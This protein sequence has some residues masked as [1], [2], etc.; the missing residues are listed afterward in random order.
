MDTPFGME[1]MSAFS[2]PGPKRPAASRSREA[3]ATPARL[4]GMDVLLDPTGALYWPRERL[5]VVSDLHLETGSSY[6][7]TGQM[8]PPYDT[9]LTLAALTMAMDRYRPSR[10]ISLGDTF[11]DTKGVSRLSPADRDHISALTGRAEFI[12][13]I[14]NHE[15]DSAAPLGGQVS[16]SLTVGA[17]TFRHIPR[18]EPGAGAEVAGH[19]HPAARI[20]VRGRAIKRRCFVGCERRLVMPAMGRLTGGLD[21]RDPAFAP[22]WPAER[23]RLHLLGPARVYAVGSATIR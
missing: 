2:Y 8:L 16:E 23:P 7:R 15:G 12:W 1:A 21:V 22:L 4:A 9:A 6:A 10:V 5:L 18:Q 11:H 13:I 14:G 3:Q 19:L 20:V 17:T